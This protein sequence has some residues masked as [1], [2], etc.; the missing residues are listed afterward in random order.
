MERAVFIHHVIR[1]YRE[2]LF[3]SWWPALSTAQIKIYDFQHRSKY[4]HSLKVRIPYTRFKLTG[5]KF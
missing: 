1:A 3:R 2:P 5:F 4:P